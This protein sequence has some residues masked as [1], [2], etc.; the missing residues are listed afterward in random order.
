[1]FF[2][3]DKVTLHIHRNIA[4]VFVFFFVCVCLCVCGLLPG[5]KPVFIPFSDTEFVFLYCVFL[6]VALLVEVSFT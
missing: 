2:T 4:F 3:V 1:M 6:D 5:S